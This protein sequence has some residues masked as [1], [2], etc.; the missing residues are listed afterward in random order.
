MPFTIANGT[1]RDLLIWVLRESGAIAAGQVPLAVDISDSFNRANLL[2]AQWQRKRWMVYH[3]LDIACIST[4]SNQY[5]VGPGQQFS[6]ANRPERI[7]SGFYR[8]FPGGASPE[9]FYIVGVRDHNQPQ[10]VSNFVPLTISSGQI[11]GQ[12]GIV[13]Y[14]LRIIRTWEDYSTVSIPT[15]ASWPDAV[16]LD[17]GWPFGTAFFYP[18][19][20]SGQFELHLQFAAVLQ[21][22]QN[23]SDTILMPPEYAAALFYNLIC[24]TRAAYGLQP[25][26]VMIALAKDGLDTVRE[27]N[28]QIPNMRM[29]SALIRGG[30]ARYNIFTDN[31]SR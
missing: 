3:L 1:I 13:D 15:L 8:Q 21:S 12:P 6:I 30:R 10:V 25:D 22:F 18:V 19:P 16:F 9:E 24:R 4:G 26:P 17:T 7:Y 2:L 11:A 29:P 5:T 31:T 23:L 20:A 28:L 14:P 27:A